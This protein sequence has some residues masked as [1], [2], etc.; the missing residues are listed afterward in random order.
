M[1]GKKKTLIA[2]NKE[3]NLLYKRKPFTQCNTR[4]RLPANAK[5]CG[6]LLRVEDESK[7]NKEWSK[8]MRRK[9]AHKLGQLAKKIKAKT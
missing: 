6:G 1:E 4:V 2:P 3:G 7:K 8:Q 9:K 5:A